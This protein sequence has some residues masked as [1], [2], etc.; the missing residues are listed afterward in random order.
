VKIAIDA[1]GTHYLNN[2]SFHTLVRYADAGKT[3]QDRIP[4]H[5]LKI[6]QTQTPQDKKTRNAQSKHKYNIPFHCFPV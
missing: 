4:Q 2:E 1:N 6:L 5:L 3:E